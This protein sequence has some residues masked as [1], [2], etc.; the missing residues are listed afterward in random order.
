MTAAVIVLLAQQGKVSLNDPV[1][2]YVPGA[3]NGDN[4]TITELLKMRS[5]LY[6]YNDDP[7]FWAILD[8][9][10]TKVWSPGP[11][12]GDRV[13]A[14]VLLSTRY[15]L[16]LLQHQL[17]AAR[18]HRRKD[19]R[20]AAGRLFPGPFVRAAGPEGHLAPRHHLE[21]PPRSLLA[22]LLV[23]RLSFSNLT[24]KP[25]PPDL[26]AAARA[27]TL[28]PDDYTGQNSSYASAAGGVIS[29][30]NDLATWIQALVGGKV[31]NADYQRQWLESL[32]PEDAKQA[33]GPKVWVRH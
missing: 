5:G 27:G 26:Q 2:K 25:Y 7:E 30:A 21:H 29:T 31:L 32:Q 14:P 13:Q 22:R 23:R 3:P 11:S 9:D 18:R 4:I 1:S 17:R 24:D 8:R 6:S 12:A 10:P 33:Q 28:K 19:G 20:E 15:G 16:P